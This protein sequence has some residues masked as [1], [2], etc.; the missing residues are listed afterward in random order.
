MIHN[1]LRSVQLLQLDI[2]KELDRICKKHDIKYWLEAGT[3]LGAVRHEGFIP[4]DDDLDVGMLSGDYKKFLK[5]AEEELPDSIF[6]QTKTSDSSSFQ[7]YA[8]LRD[9]NSL[10]IEY[11]TDF[12]ISGHKGVYI[13]IFEFD[14]YPD[15]SKKT[16]RFFYNK[17]GKTTDIL[18]KKQKLSLKTILQYFVFNIQRV[19]FKFIWKL[20]NKKKSKK[21]IANIIED[22]GYCVKQKTNSIFPLKATKFEGQEFPAPNDSD[23]YLKSLYG[24][25]MELPPIEK[26][27][28]HAY[29][30]FINLN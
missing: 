18:S 11:Q 12:S 16:I 1:D 25:Y 15:I 13:D 24:N 22:N 28:G 2:L 7:N 6:L 3:L 26:R 19:T 4:W 10:Y 29:A 5:I 27:G 23:S 21:F 9:T 17:I 14:Y 30:Y 8:K 20:M